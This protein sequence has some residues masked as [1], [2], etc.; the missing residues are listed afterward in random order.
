MAR[1]NLPDPQLGYRP[2]ECRR[3]G[4]TL[5]GLTPG[6]TVTCPECGETHYERACLRCGYSLAGL[7][8]A[9]VCPECNEPYLEQSLVL[10]GVPKNA[11]SGY[12]R[13]LWVLL[14]LTAVAVVQ[15]WFLMP[16]W[17]V[18]ILGMC[19]LLGIPAMLMTSKRERSGVERFVLS[20]GGICRIPFALPRHRKGTP[21]PARPADSLFIPWGASDTVRIKRISPYWKRIQIGRVS[22]EGVFKNIVFDAGFRCPDALME[23]VRVDIQRVIDAYH[24]RAQEEGPHDRGP[25]KPSAE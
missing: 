22:A 8:D 25:S 6:E 9:G 16:G 11:S 20:P 7:P 15:F 18:I 24:S 4:Y 23:Q 5:E 14:F 17:M 21:P 2:R 12:R 19:M 10:A 1:Q 3:C 13:A